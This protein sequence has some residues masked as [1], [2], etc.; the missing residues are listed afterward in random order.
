MTYVDEILRSQLYTRE[1][2]AEVDAGR[3]VLLAADAFSA[4]P[5]SHT[6]DRMLGADVRTYLPGDLLVKMDIAT[7][8]HSLEA[9]SP[10]LDHELMETVARLPVHEKVRGM[11][12]KVALKN[13]F[14]GIVDDDLLDRP[15]RG[16]A[17][18]LAEWF[19]GPLR[20]TAHAVL[21]DRR[22]TE[23]GQ[24]RRE[25]VSGLLAEH[26]RAGRDRGSEL[27]LLLVFELWQRRFLDGDPESALL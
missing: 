2:A 10:F 13:A 16:F 8:A 23:R 27:W 20:E 26:D 17:V 4:A 11:T 6:V 12:T 7:M 25:V 22:T 9:R 15:K 18:P 19:R 5:A 24:F 21:L 3:T 14:R 1:F